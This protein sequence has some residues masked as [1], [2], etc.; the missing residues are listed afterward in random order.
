MKKAM[1]V[2]RA[3]LLE[4]IIPAPGLIKPIVEQ[5]TADP[6]PIKISVI[7]IFSFYLV[8]YVSFYNIHY[9]F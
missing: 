6:V 5:P 2:N 9:R 1:L 7:I 3:V 4:V 8:I